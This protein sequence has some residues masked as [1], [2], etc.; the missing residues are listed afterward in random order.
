[1]RSDTDVIP[2]IVKLGI[3]LT[4]LNSIFEN[5]WPTWFGIPRV[6]LVPLF[7]LLLIAVLIWFVRGERRGSTRSEESAD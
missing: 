4:L 7:G 1:M 2:V 5:Q 6:F 3:I